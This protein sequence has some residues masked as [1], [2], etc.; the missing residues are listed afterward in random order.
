M[1]I[2]GGMWVAPPLYLERKLRWDENMRK[3]AWALVGFAVAYTACESPSETVVDTDVASTRAAADTPDTQPPTAPTNLHVTA[4]T[5]NTISLAWNASTD[6]SGSV[7]YVIRLQGGSYPFVIDWY[8]ST[9][10]TLGGLD[11][12]T[13]FTITVTARDESANFSAPSNTVTVTTDPRDTEAP[14]APSGLRV[15]G[16]TSTSVSLAWE[17][18]TDNVAVVTYWIHVDGVIMRGTGET[19]FTYTGLAPATTYQFAVSAEDGAVPSS[20][21]SSPSNTVTATTAR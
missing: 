6:N 17:P 2:T 7:I 13:P 9:S 15:T 4:Q 3:T 18:S 10:I 1:S 8:R 16:T 11:A 21:R 20:N 5:P 12:G 19:S 14:T